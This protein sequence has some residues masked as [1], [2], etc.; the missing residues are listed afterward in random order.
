MLRSG[1]LGRFNFG[2]PA[3]D[4]LPE[5]EAVL[6]IPTDNTSYSPDEPG[7]FRFLPLG[8]WAAYELRI[9]AWEQPDLHLVLSDIPWLGDE[10]G[11]ATTGTLS[12][13]SW[14]TS[15][16]RFTVDDQLAV[17]SSVADLRAHHPDIVLGTF[18]VCETEYDPA[19]FVTMPYDGDTPP[20]WRGLRGT[21]DWDWVSDLQIALNEQ[22][23]SLAVD[24]EYGPR[25]RAALH[26]YQLAEGI[27]Q[28]TA[29]DANGL[30][31]PDTVGA[32]GLE[33]PEGA[34]IVG[35]A[36]GYPGSC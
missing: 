18:D 33:V 23:A 27:D 16:P 31:G 10:F 1:G 13:V 2:E 9:A 14:A 4:L 8:Y 36:A 24:G 11:D 6:G 28:G 32:L 22:G 30:I 15:S 21:T 20:L 35:L 25:T 7:P 26:Q 19:A 5:L 17:G 12:L 29:P 34:R 3:N